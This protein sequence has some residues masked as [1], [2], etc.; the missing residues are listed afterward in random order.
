[1]AQ[2]QVVGVPELQIQYTVRGVELPAAKRQVFAPIGGAE[3]YVHQDV[4]RDLDEAMEGVAWELCCMLGCTARDFRDGVAGLLSCS[5]GKLPRLY[6]SL[7][8]PT[9]PENVEKIF[10]DCHHHS[11]WK[12]PTQEYADSVAATASAATSASVHTKSAELDAPSKPTGAV[13]AAPHS[14]LGSSESS[15]LL[16]VPPMPGILRPCLSDGF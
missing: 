13:Q 1:M 14:S 5:R 8:L 15:T 4:I 3:L 6:A 16:P 7:H 11:S 9:L 12:R 10:A 2:L